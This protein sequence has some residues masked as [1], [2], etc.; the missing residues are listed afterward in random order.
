M[1]FKFGNNLQ[2][3][4]RYYGNYVFPEQIGNKVAIDLGCNVGLFVMENYN[5]FENFHAIDASYENFLVTLRR[6]LHKNLKFGEAE[7]V[8]CF[9][10]AAARNTGEVIKIYAH[11]ANGNSVSPMTVPEMFTKQYNNWKEQNETYHNVF[12]ISLEGLYEF[13]NIDYI[14]YL[15]IDI[16]GAEFDFLLG[17]DLSKIGCLALELHGTLGQEMKEKMKQ[18]LEKYF[19]VYHVDYDLPA[20]QHSV[21]TY[22]NKEL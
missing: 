20:P 15:K 1:K 19:N 11:D 5:K 10:L 9:N 14:D 22:I 3:Q 6:V 7:N 16:E 12:T 2:G 13:F 17:K 21:I 4:E 18:H 8:S